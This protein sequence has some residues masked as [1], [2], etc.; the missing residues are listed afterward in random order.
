[1]QVYIDLLKKWRC[2]QSSCASSTPTD[3]P[4]SPPIRKVSTRQKQYHEFIRRMFAKYR[5]T[6]QRISLSTVADQWRSLP[7]PE[8]QK[9]G[10]QTRDSMLADS[11][12]DINAEAFDLS[13][14]I[15]SMNENDTVI[16]TCVQR[17][18]QR[19]CDNQKKKM[20]R[21]QRKKNCFDSSEIASS[22]RRGRPPGEGGNG[23]TLFL[24]SRWNALIREHSDRQ[25]ATIV[26]SDDSNRGV[27]DKRSNT[28][29]SRSLFAHISRQIGREWRQLDPEQQEVSHG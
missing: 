2:L 4:I 25:T 24:Q 8:K 23:Y 14:L 18:Q 13:S 5:D 11:R 19:T 7:E 15:T 12:R 17:L 22:K 3:D 26:N 21:S 29:V 6:G 1:M 16:Q 28:H 9:L 20:I 10:S 27:H